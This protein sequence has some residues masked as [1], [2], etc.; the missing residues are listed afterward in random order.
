MKTIRDICIKYLNLP[1]KKALFL[2]GLNLIVCFYRLGLRRY[3]N[4]LSLY[5]RYPNNV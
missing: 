3:E 4:V 1:I 5:P 2:G